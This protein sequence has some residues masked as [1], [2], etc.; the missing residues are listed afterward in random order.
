MRYGTTRQI[1]KEIILSLLVHLG[2][3]VLI[4]Y[5]N[6]ILNWATIVATATICS[7]HNFNVADVLATEKS[8]KLLRDIHFGLEYD[9]IRFFRKRLPCTCLRERYNLVKNQPKMMIC[10]TCK[11]QRDRRQLYLC[12]RCRFHHYCSIE[13]QAKHFPT[14][15]Q[16]CKGAL[17]GCD[18]PIKRK[19]DTS[20]F[21][22]A[23]LLS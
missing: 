22:E 9:T 15:Q 8:R 20:S 11:T 4:K 7:Q 17:Q 3:N 21:E 19:K 12:S 14:H 5:D 13:C 2:A 1:R 16:W 6:S 10:M 23:V 18:S